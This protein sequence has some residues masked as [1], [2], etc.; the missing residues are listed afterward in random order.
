[1]I[2]I[3]KNQLFENNINTNSLNNNENNNSNEINIEKEIETEN[4]KEKEKKINNEKL[5]LKTKGTNQTKLNFLAVSSRK[6]K[7]IT[8]NKTQCQKLTKNKDGFCDVHRNQKESL[9]DQY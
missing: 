9:D 4:E 8:L 2:Q 6:C 3:E 7:G 5:L 1:M